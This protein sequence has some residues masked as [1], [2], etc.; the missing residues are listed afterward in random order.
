MRVL[1]LGG[2]GAL[3]SAI[4]RYAL[5]RGLET[6]VLVRETTDLTRLGADPAVAVHRRDLGNSRELAALVRSLTPQLIANAAFP[7]GHPEDDEARRG[8]LLGM[9][10]NLLSLFNGLRDAEFQGHLVLLGSAMSYGTGGALL[11]TTDSLRPQTFRGAVKAAESGLAAQMASQF[12]IALTE[13]RVFTGYGPF[14]QRERLVAQLLRAALTGTRVRLT[15][16]AF[17]RDW[18]YY[19]DIARACIAAADSSTG[20]ARVFNICTGHVTSTHR[21]AA[22]LERIV[23]HELIAEEPYEAGDR[24]GDIGTGVGPSSDDGLDWQPAVSLEEGLDASWTWA[25]S[26]VGTAYLL[27]REAIN[28]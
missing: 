21:V 27:G 15:K 16:L 25:L 4:A 1:I 23:G 13:L 17:Q 14:E 20:K 6:H 9:T 10:N 8:L 7:S 11:R 28:G 12:G 3:G 5:N 18:V 2:G 22:I 19:D 26:P 24:Y